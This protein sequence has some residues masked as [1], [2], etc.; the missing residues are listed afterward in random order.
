MEEGKKKQTL[1]HIEPSFDFKSSACTVNWNKMSGDGRIRWCAQC[2]HF[3]YNPERLSQSEL[4]SL[5]WFREG[6]NAQVLYR[7]TDGKVQTR[8]CRNQSYRMAARLVLP[9]AAMSAVL[10][11]VGGLASA[12][13]PGQASA[14]ASLSSASSNIAITKSVSQQ[15]F[16]AP[17]QAIASSKRLVAPMA[18]WTNCAS[19]Q[20]PVASP[21]STP[22]QFAQNEPPVTQ[23][24]PVIQQLPT[25]QEITQSTAAFNDQGAHA[26][27]AVAPIAAGLPPA[28]QATFPAAVAKQQVSL[29]AASYLCGR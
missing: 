12:L 26:T 29:P 20:M 1:V 18:T 21:L 22:Q 6:I 19:Y 5:I 11:L 25:P 7:R 24:I 3:V 16:K 28:A 4:A 14:E 15:P 23:R 10:V 13:Q 2:Q 9:A 17:A 27:I 8:N